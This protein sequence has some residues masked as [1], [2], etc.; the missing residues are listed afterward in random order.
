MDNSEIRGD[1]IA[2]DNGEDDLYLIS[3]KISKNGEQKA[4]EDIFPKKPETRALHIK[5]T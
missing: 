4:E 2:T 1:V 5:R 3:S